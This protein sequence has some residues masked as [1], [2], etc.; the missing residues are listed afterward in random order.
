MTSNPDPNQRYDAGLEL[1]RRT[2]G[3]AYV[4]RALDSATDFTRPF[5]EF[6][7][8]F[9]WGAV[10]DAPGLP[11]RSRSLV[12][13]AILAALNQQDEL[14]LHL[15]AALRNGCDPVELRETLFHV[16]LYAGLPAAVTG[17]R[18]AQQV[19]DEAGV[20]PAGTR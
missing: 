4:Q 16:G 14:R 9:A 7:T 17:F 10:W 18:I 19:L 8:E 13:V 1:R 6:V 2:L 20:S 11:A 5:Q 12:T 15:Q 3:E